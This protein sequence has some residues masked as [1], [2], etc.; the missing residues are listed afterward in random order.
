MF[1]IRLCEIPLYSPTAKVCFFLN[2]STVPFWLT[3]LKS[4]SLED[5]FLSN[6]RMCFQNL[7]RQ[8][9][10]V[11]NDLSSWLLAWPSLPIEPHH[12]VGKLDRDK[13]GHVQFYGRTFSCDISLKPSGWQDLL[14]S[15][16]SFFSSEISRVSYLLIRLIGCQSL[17]LGLIYSQIWRICELLKAVWNDKT[18][19]AAPT[20]SSL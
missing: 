4:L 14:S 10:D 17:K 11:V 15:S 8:S 19:W 20:P 7:V 1:L 18:F 2:F 13:G 12:Q 3:R 16:T 9:C 6:L 5:F